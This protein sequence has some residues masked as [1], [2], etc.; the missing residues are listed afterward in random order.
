MP[1]D[2]TEREQV[3]P[4]QLKAIEVASLACGRLAATVES[5]G[6]AA[7]DFLLVR[8]AVRVHDGSTDLAAELLLARATPAL[9][10]LE[11]TET[12]AA[13]APATAHSS[14][15]M[16]AAIIAGTVVATTPSSPELQRQAALVG[17][18]AL[19]AGG[20]LP[21]P[22]VAPWQLDAAARSAAVQIDRSASWEEWIRSWCNLL[23]REA[24]GTERALRAATTQIE[25]ERAEARSHHR[26]GGTD[27]DV[28]GW[29]QSHLSFTI[30]D[31]S[32]SLGLTRP[33]VGTAIERLESLGIATELTGRKRDRVWVSATMLA[34]AATR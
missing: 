1:H 22:W 8:H 11:P 15:I 4:G 7:S 27:A 17:A 19:V 6:G 33:T 12:L 23:A 24:A 18:L 5:A 3:G 14:S 26:V 16:R 9:A 21:E 32:D 25:A 31:A 29:L 28:L 10:T 2:D 13:A 34:L 20:T 30:R